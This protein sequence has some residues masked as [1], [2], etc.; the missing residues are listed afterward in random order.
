MRPFVDS[1][2][3]IDDGPALRERVERDGY[4]F[5]PKLLPTELIE[6]VRFQYLEIL[7]D[8]GWLKQGT[9]LEDMVAELDAFCVE[10]E[11]TYTD[12]LSNVYKLPGFHAIPQHP[13]L[14]GV[15]ER[16]LDA[17]V[18]PMPHVITRAMFPQREEYTTPPHQDFVFIQGNEDVYTAWI[19][20]SDLPPESGG[21]QLASG[22]NHGGIYDFTPAL[23]AGGVAVTADLEDSWVYSPF[24]QGDVLIFNSM[25]VH[26]GVP[27]TG[28]RMRLSV[29]TRFQRVSDPMSESSLLPHGGSLT[30][31]EIYADWPT[32]THKYY[33]RDLDLNLVEFDHSY[34]E[35][36]DEMAIEMAKAGDKTSRSALQRM[37]ARSPDPARREQ[38]VALLARLD[39]N[40][41]DS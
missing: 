39:A 27:A 18:I 15:M 38:A 14:L 19:P 36:R 6:P 9:A 2:E 11:P 41:D 1:S 10:P 20:L 5:L 29:D 8:A 16:L 3:L 17:P 40:A 24:H 12:V 33:W 7:R 34:A 21:L 25:T 23:G 22:S 13:N 26:Q 30:W 31:E 32:D 37:A 35:K 4:L 28:E